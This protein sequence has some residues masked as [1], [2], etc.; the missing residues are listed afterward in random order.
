MYNEKIDHNLIVLIETAIQNNQFYEYLTGKDGYK[1]EIKGHYNFTSKNDPIVMIKG[2]E[3]YVKQYP[4][5]KIDDYVTKHLLNFASSNDV[6]KIFLALEFVRAYIYLEKTKQISFVIDI[7][8]VLQLLRNNLY[9]LKEVLENPKQSNLDL[10]DES[11]EIVENDSRF[12]ER[13]T[14][15]KI[16]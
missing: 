10:E 6:A 3:L 13:Y 4:Q 12:I 14:G 1:F 8:P 7:L 5:F 2:L 11:W 9:K 15:H 16:L